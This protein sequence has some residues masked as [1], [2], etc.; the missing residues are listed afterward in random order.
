M[1]NRTIF[2]SVPSS[3]IL[4]EFVGSERNHT[5]DSPCFSWYLYLLKNYRL[6]ISY[7]KQLLFVLFSTIPRI[8]RG[9]HYWLDLLR[10]PKPMPIILEDSAYR[11]STL[12]LLQPYSSS[13]RNI[14][15]FNSI[16]ANRE[17]RA[18]SFWKR[19]CRYLLLSFKCLDA[20]LSVSCLVIVSR[21]WKVS[22]K[23]V[24]DEIWSYELLL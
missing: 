20:R 11:E 9:F 14:C 15:G 12:L 5:K 23:P 1:T 2:L 16:F 13:Y 18:H 19:S 10:S 3:H 4:S 17:E 21:Y 7:K 8:M 22:C 6:D 24:L